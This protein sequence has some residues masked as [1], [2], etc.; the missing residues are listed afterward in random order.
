MYAKREYIDNW[1]IGDQ[2]KKDELYNSIKSKKFLGDN[3]DCALQALYN[4]IFNFEEAKSYDDLEVDYQGMK[5][6]K[7]QK[8][9]LVKTPLEQMYGKKKTEQE[10]KSTRMKFSYHGTWNSY[11]VVGTLEKKDIPLNKDGSQRQPYAIKLGTNVTGIGE[12]ALSECHSLASIS[13]PITVTQIEYDVFKECTTLQSVEFEGRTFREVRQMTNYPWGI[14]DVNIIN[15]GAFSDVTVDILRE[16]ITTFNNL[17]VRLPVDTEHNCLA[18]KHIWQDWKAFVDGASEELFNR[19]EL[20]VKFSG[21]LHDWE[22][23][24]IEY[25]IGT[26]GKPSYSPDGYP[27]TELYVDSKCTIPLVDYSYIVVEDGKANYDR[28]DYWDENDFKWP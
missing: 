14:S 28:F 9:N 25:G 21:T 4:Y 11:D 10:T 5:L 24:R 6:T 18:S 8:E 7:D 1:C 15:R 26:N 12:D 16:R 2:R 13:I 17:I 22:H 20:F 27:Y 19:K 3:Q 23:R